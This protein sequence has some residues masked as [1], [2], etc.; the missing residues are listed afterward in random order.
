MKSQQNVNL[1]AAKNNSKFI[2]GSPQEEIGESGLR[3]WRFQ[4][5]R[6]ER[7]QVR[8]QDYGLG[9]EPAVWYAK[10]WES[11]QGWQLK[12]WLI[13]LNRGKKIESTV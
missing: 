3:V 2:I 9:S 10:F 13:K 1:E 5:R 11:E 12:L 8:I 4:S 7:V 6:G